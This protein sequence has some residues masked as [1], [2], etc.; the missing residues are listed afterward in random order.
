MTIAINDLKGILLP[1]TTPFDPSGNISASGITSNIKEW[2]AR[3]VIGFVVLGSTGERVHLDEREYLEVIEISRA[4]RRGTTEHH[5]H[6]Q[7]D[8]ERRSSRRSGSA[9][10]HALFLSS[11]Y[12]AGDAR[13]LLHGCC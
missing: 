8:Q 9:R 6:N 7:R 12:H 5:R 13:Q 3:G 11:G 4:A 10:Y 2:T 1:T